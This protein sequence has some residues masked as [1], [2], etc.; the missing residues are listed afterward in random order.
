MPIE[1]RV[2]DPEPEKT[3]KPL[4]SYKD[5]LYN[6]RRAFIHALD[7]YGY[8][9]EYKPDTS[10]MNIFEDGVTGRKV[11]ALLERYERSSLHRLIQDIYEADP[12]PLSIYMR[13]QSITQAHPGTNRYEPA[14]FQHSIIEAFFMAA[15]ERNGQR[16]AELQQS[17]REKGYRTEEEIVE[18]TTRI[19]TAGVHGAEYAYGKSRGLT[20]IRSQ[21]LPDNITP[22]IRQLVRE[23]FT[24]NA[25]YHNLA[26]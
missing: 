15:Y 9:F 19:R 23:D 16:V 10:A 3:R 20:S 5:E 14:E 25:A 17:Y 6:S 22:F 26:S 4:I 24:L 2:S 7:H 8:Q 11:K 18:F 1:Q 21:E 13:T 12:A